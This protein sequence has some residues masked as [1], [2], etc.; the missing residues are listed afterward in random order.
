M[1]QAAI[2]PFKP[3]MVYPVCLAAEIGEFFSTVARYYT[4]ARFLRTDL[5]CFLAYLMRSPE[6]ICRRY[7]RDMPDD[8]VQKIYGETFFTTLEEIADAVGLSDR[9]VI[10]DLGCGRGRSVFWFNALRGCRAVGVDINRYFVIQARRI[11]RKADI[12]GVEFVLGNV[13]D[14]D[15]DD[16]TVIY[17]YGT[18]FSDAAVVRLVR[19]FESLKPGTRVVTVSYPLNTYAKA[20]MFALEK[21]IKGKFAWGETEIYIQRKL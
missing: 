19:R 18:A 21:T 2:A 4:N 11:Q 12:E 3:L 10:Y 5:H 1:L 9:D 17:L 14:L 6:A 15:Y 20:P 7:L 8:D 16:A 13:L